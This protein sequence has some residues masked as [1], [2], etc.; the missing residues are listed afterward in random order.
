M[1]IQSGNLDGRRQARIEI[2]EDVIALR[3][4][5]FIL[6]AQAEVQ[7]QATGSFPVLLHESG[8]VVLAE[9]DVG[10]IDI[11]SGGWHAENKRRRAV[12][13]AGARYCRVG[14][15]GETAV[16]S[17]IAGPGVARVECR[18]ALVVPHLQR[19]RRKYFCDGD[20]GVPG[21]SAA[22]LIAQGA[23]VCQV[24]DRGVREC[25]AW[26]EI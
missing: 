21:N 20:T 10:I 23:K 18:E 16:E 6:P 7:R 3:E 9:S 2:R 14:P 17:E 5:R 1:Q 4:R 12:A 8:V 25:T 26:C 24:A 15:L 22:D 13:G 11:V 19:M